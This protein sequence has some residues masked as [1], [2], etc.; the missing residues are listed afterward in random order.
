MCLQSV[1]L[2]PSDLTEEFVVAFRNEP[3]VMSNVSK[4]PSTAR[5]NHQIEEEAKSDVLWE[6]VNVFESSRGLP[7]VQGE[8]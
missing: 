4:M 6:T 3:F 8:K 1:D 2:Q 7:G 5:K